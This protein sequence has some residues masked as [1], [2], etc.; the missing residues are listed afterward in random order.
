MQSNPSLELWK[1]D[2]WCDSF[3]VM[4]IVVQK[5][6]LLFVD[7]HRE[8]YKREMSLKRGASESIWN[9]LARRKS[10]FISLRDLK[11]PTY[12]PSGIFYKIHVKTDNKQSPKSETDFF[13]LWNYVLKVERDDELGRNFNSQLHFSCNPETLQNNAVQESETKIVKIHVFI[14]KKIK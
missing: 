12:T 10:I 14:R 2:I 7:K 11:F 5:G 9:W 3:H 1:I 13:N 6:T 4:Q 8:Q